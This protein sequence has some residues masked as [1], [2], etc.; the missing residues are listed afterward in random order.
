MTLHDISLTLSET[1]PT[2][3]G[4]PV[5]QLRQISS[6]AE[7]DDANVTQVSMSVHTGTHIDAPDHFLGNG[8]TV[9]N[10]PLDLLVGKAVVVEIL[11]EGT[12]TKEDLKKWGSRQASPGS[13]LKPA[14]QPIGLLEIRNSR[15][16]LLPWGKTPPNTW[17]RS[18]SRSLVWI[19]CP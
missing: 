2:W 6:I 1:L 13:C 15:K 11:T 12:I 5:I 3:P 9:D 17:F 14:I 18:G 4:D 19:I 7:G 10:I 8:D 16:I